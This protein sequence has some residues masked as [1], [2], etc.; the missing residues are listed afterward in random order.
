MSKHIRNER[1]IYTY[2]TILRARPRVLKYFTEHIFKPRTGSYHVGASHSFAGYARKAMSEFLHEE[3]GVFGIHNRDGS[4]IS[5][6]MYY[7]LFALQHRGQESCGIA[8]RRGNEIVCHKGMG[9]VAEV[10][11]PAVLS[12]LNGSAAIGHVRYS[13][14]GRSVYEN[15]Q[16]IVTQ[17]SKGAISIA[18]NGN[19]T[20][21][22]R[23]RSEL[24]EKGAIFQTDTDSEVLAY[25]IAGNRVKTH[26]IEMAVAEMMNVVRGA[27]SLLIMTPGKL[28][29]ARDRF[30]F[31][32]LC[33]GKIGGSEVFASESSALDAIGAEFVRD[34]LPGEIVICDATGMRS[35]TPNP[36]GKP[37]HCI[38]EYIY[39][40]RPD[41]VI[42]QVS[43]Y[44]AR[45]RAGRLLA[46]VHPVEADAVIGVP[47]SG[48]DAAA[49]YSHETGIPFVRGFYKNSYVGRTFI[50]P[51]QSMRLEAVG[52]KL[53]P[54]RGTVSGKKIILIDDS[55]VRGTTIAHIVGM[56]RKCGA[57]EVHVRISAPPFLYPCFFG[58][59]VPTG[60]MLIAK[61][62]TIEQI[63]RQ[64]GA[65]SLGYLDIGSLSRMIGDE[66][67]EYCDACF[68]GDY[69]KGSVDDKEEP[70]KQ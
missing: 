68:S 58:T 49:G 61:A 14:A 46:S 35:V 12:G 62:N 18:H 65:D 34:V 57:K 1:E 4:D 13:T 25:M 66:K 63:A 22:D 44:E 48:M 69:P 31:R 54:I 70:K 52:I 56:L 2:Y 6:R 53:N 27:Y 37:S 8:V 45:F 7:G 36:P 43:V 3:C 26:S 29:A 32:P 42:D 9:L 17:Y 41:S 67:H 40:A 21:A 51:E 23:L 19:L 5:I 28:I 11:S 38:F 24:S 16:P 55:I 15:A 59:D 20:N 64:I 60:D 33:I 10:F 50:K 39:F 30:G 47:E